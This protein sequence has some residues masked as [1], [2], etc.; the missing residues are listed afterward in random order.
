M[1]QCFVCSVC[2][3]VLRGVTMRPHQKGLANLQRQPGRTTGALSLETQ[4]FC[5]E[6]VSHRPVFQRHECVCPGRLPSPHQHP[7]PHVGGRRLRDQ[8]LSTCPRGHH[9]W[10]LLLFQDSQRCSGV[11]TSQGV[12]AHLQALPTARPCPRRAALPEP[13]PKSY[14]LNRWKSI[15][16]FQI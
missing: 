6:P 10:N 13:S 1:S 7:R 3:G 9:L 15:S 2:F 8:E 11:P 12:Y 16:H 4:S 5:L 14:H